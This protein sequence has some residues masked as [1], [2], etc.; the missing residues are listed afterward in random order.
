MQLNMYILE[1]KDYIIDTNQRHFGSIEQNRNSKMTMI[2]RS[3]VSPSTAY[4][5]I[6]SADSLVMPIY[7]PKNGDDCYMFLDITKKQAR[8][9][10]KN[11]NCPTIHIENHETRLH[12][13]MYADE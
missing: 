8:D 12:F 13:S 3:D 10:V 6:K 5:F 4:A 11:G 2:M 9:L 1:L 7:N